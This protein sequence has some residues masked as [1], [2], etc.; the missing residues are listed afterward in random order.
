MRPK[1]RSRKHQ[2]KRLLLPNK[3]RRLN[4]RRSNLHQRKSKDIP[5]TPSLTASS[6]LLKKKK[7]LKKRKR[8]R[9][10]KKR[11]KR[12]LKANPRLYLI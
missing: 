11:R 3:R 4:R 2:R 10:L 12:A 8:L 1:N 6:R 9:L 7:N 5:L